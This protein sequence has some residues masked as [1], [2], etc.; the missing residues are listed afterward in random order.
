MCKYA[1]RN[2]WEISIL[3]IINQ[4]T[5]PYKIRSK[6]SSHTLYNDAEDNYKVLHGDSEEQQ[7]PQITIEDTINA[8]TAL[9]PGKS[10]CLDDI[11]TEFLK[12]GGE[13][14]ATSLMNP[15]NRI[16]ETRKIPQAF[17]DAMIVVIF[18]KGSRNE[19]KKYR[20]ISLL[21]NIYKVFVAIICERVKND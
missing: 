18:K 15:C 1:I 10:A 8:I 2:Q 4:I 7:I 12:C 19:C 16:I 17:K 14:V 11:H 13:I 3:I 9:K 5:Y 21:S 6:A 20:P